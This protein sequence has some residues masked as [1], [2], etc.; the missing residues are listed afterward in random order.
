MEQRA[1]VLR[2]VAARTFVAPEVAIRTDV[3]YASCAKS[4]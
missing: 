3:L 2:E 4:G 1:L